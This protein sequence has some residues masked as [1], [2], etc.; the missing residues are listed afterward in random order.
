MASRLNVVDPVAG[1]YS[2]S[3]QDEQEV[4]TNNIG[5]RTTGGRYASSYMGAR[6]RWWDLATAQ[7]EL[8]STG[9]QAHNDRIRQE[10]ANLE[11]ARSNILQGV[12]QRADSMARSLMMG[13]TRRLEWNAQTGPIV[14]TTTHSP[15][16]GRGYGRG[17]IQ[18]NSTVKYEIDALTD[19]HIISPGGDNQRLQA[20]R[21]ADVLWDDDAS[22]NQQAAALLRNRISDLRTNI[23]ETDGLSYEDAGDQAY[24][25]MRTLYTEDEQGRG[26]WERFEQVQEATRA[27][28]GG[29]WSQTRRN[30]RDALAEFYNPETGELTDNIWEVDPFMFDQETTINRI[31]R[32]ILERQAEIQP[33][34]SVIDRA[35]EVNRQEFGPS[36]LQSIRSFK[37]DRAQRNTQRD[38]ERSLSHYLQNGG[39]LNEL[40]QQLNGRSVREPSTEQLEVPR[41][42]ALDEQGV[43]VELQPIDTNE[44]GVTSDASTAPA[45]TGIVRLPNDNTYEYQKVNGQWV[46]RRIGTNDW[47]DFSGMTPEARQQANDT[48]N[49]AFPR[50]PVVEAPAVQKVAEPEGLPES[51]DEQ[52]DDRLPSALSPNRLDNLPIDS[53]LQE[54]I[55]RDSTR[56]RHNRNLLEAANGAADRMSRPNQLQRQVANAEEGSPAAFARTTMDAW[57]DMDPVNRPALQDMIGNLAQQYN[58]VDDIAGRTE[59]MEYL[60]GMYQLETDSSMLG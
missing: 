9:I 57:R 43:N 11:D 16:Q 25:V 19:E 52:L 42:T 40:L 51:E 32:E 35:R 56:Q 55:E 6:S 49:A 31:D 38:A 24:D 54:H 26:L 30:G 3:F 7:A 20:L 36:I 8:E 12:P 58:G 47:I 29:R 14:S 60:M 48:L 50:A 46:T 23:M 2:L 53:E 5:E 4:P 28:M 10:I 33:Q 13:N 37:G 1:I 44:I 18:P 15:S 45:R 21:D 41:A 27:E 39:D 34:L 22:Q 17:R 59:A